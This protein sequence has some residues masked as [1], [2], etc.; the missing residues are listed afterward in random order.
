MQTVI[1]ASDSAD[2]LAVVP[3]LAGFRP[4]D[5]LA[6]VLFDGKRSLGVMRLDLPH[7]GDIP[8]IAATMIGM[9]CRVERADAVVFVTYTDDPLRTADGVLAQ[10]DLLDALLDRAHACGLWVKDALCVA[11]DAWGSYVD[12][13]MGA[14]A[15]TEIDD[16]ARQTPLPA[17]PEGADQHT[18]T[19][20]PQVGEANRK[21]TARALAALTKAIR[22]ITTHDPKDLSGIDPRAL[23]TA[24][25]LDDVPALFEDAL[26]WSSDGPLP[27]DA[28]ALIWCLDRPSLRDIA[29]AQWC[30]DLEAGQEAVEA[31]FAWEQGADYPDGV[32]R[33][34]WGEGPRPNVDRV[35]RAL[36]LVRECAALAPRRQRPGLLAAAAWM[37][38]ALG[39]S[40]HADRYAKKA[41]QIDPEH[42]LSEIVMTMVAAGHLPEWAFE[43][44]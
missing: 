32:A 29:I 23:A 33:Q 43:R 3:H 5:S 11:Q 4:R 30:G 37:S 2:F 15:L 42:G 20:L 17:V 9:M 13:S 36:E 1:R 6:V 24:C 10:Q 14:R 19:T 21:E 7:G 31:Q 27:T 39:R 35:Q 28:A 26:T 8:R 38:W 12:A 34:F 44:E 25:A 18:G 16:R 41:L 40:T 22:A